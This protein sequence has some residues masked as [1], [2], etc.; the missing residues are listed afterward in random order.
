MKDSEYY[1]GTNFENLS[2]GDPDFFSDISRIY[3]SEKSNGDEL[4]SNYSL[5][6]VENDIKANK[7]LINFSGNRGYIIGKS[8]EIR[9]VAR[10]KVF[11]LNENENLY[12][13]EGG[14]IRLIK[15][16]DSTNQA[17][18]LLNHEGIVSI[19]GSKIVIGDIDK[20]KEN[21]KS[22]QVYI[23]HGA[24]EPLVLG[25]FLKNKLENFMNEVCKSL[26][27]INKN[28]DEI[29]TKFNNH[30]DEYDTHI[31]TFNAVP[32]GSPPSPT[33]PTTVPSASQISNSL[34]IPDKLDKEG[35]NDPV[36]DEE[37]DGEYGTIKDMNLDPNK[38]SDN[39]QN[40]ILIKNSLVEVLSMLGKTL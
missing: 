3:V 9:L 2:E 8:D 40:I 17:S 15:E 34:T 10:N 24:K 32:P 5:Y 6:T 18:V 19:N 36:K 33:F 1:L 22:E 25:Y 23:G 38:I 27:L 29:N 30:L 7:K 26:V 39:I 4:I 21:G 14:S 20:V 35:I 37:K 28:L 11:D 31:H 16:G 12:Q 13:G